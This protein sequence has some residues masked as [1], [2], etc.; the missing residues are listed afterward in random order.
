MDPYVRERFVIIPAPKVWDLE[1]TGDDEEN[2]LVS[3]D[4]M[5]VMHES[6][7]SKLIGSQRVDVAPK[8]LQVDSDDEI[9][10]LV[11]RR[12]DGFLFQTAAFNTRVAS[13]IEALRDK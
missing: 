5:L 9:P 4:D 12:S 8:M 3:S 11:P 2:E 10:E 7:S 6:M 13:L 1:D